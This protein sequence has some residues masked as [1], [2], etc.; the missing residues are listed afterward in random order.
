MIYRCSNCQR[1]FREGDI[2][3]GDECPTCHDGFVEMYEKESD[4]PNETEWSDR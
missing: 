4:W 3:P 2:V 1:R